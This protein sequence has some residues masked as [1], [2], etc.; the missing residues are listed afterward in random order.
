MTNIQ[1]QLARL[2]EDIRH[3]KATEQEETRSN[4]A[5]ELESNRHNVATETTARDQVIIT[6]NVAQE[7]ARHNLVMEDQ[8]QMSINEQ[9]RHNTQTEIE[10]SRSNLAKEQEQ[11]RHN[12]AVELETSRHNIVDESNSTDRN[13]I[14]MYDAVTKRKSQEADALYKTATVALNTME[15]NS[16]IQERKDKIDLQKEK[17]LIDAA[18]AQANLMRSY[19]GKVN[20]SNRPN[21]NGSVRPNQLWDNT[22]SVIN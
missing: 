14:N 12:Q 3:N 10:T 18:N 16:R 17:L 1:L 19:A 22:I 2:K 8:N 15:T 9:I 7:T 20:Y 21:R 5:K 6:A 13:K 11:A 4:V